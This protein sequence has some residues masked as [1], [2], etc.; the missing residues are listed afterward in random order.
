MSD[1]NLLKVF[2][3]VIHTKSVTKAAKELGVSSPAVSQA[4]NRLKQKYNDPL[5]IREGRGL[6]P[7]SFS[8][9]LYDKIKEPLSI[10]NNI[11]DFEKDF[12]PLTSTLTFRIQTNSDLDILFYAN[13]LK[14]L[15]KEAPNLNIDFFSKKSGEEESIQESL[16]Y[17]KTDLTIS[18]IETKEKSYKSHL[19]SKE[20]IVGIA[21]ENNDIFK[22][23]I[24]L[25][26]F[27]NQK[28]AIYYQKRESD[29]FANSIA[30]NNLKERKS[31]YT[32]QS[33]LNLMIMCKKTNLIGI[34]CESYYNELKEIGGLKIFELP[35]DHDFLPI[36]VTS[37]KNNNKDKGIQWL[38]EILKRS[39]N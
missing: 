30:R 16:I 2:E 7:T 1:L 18:T 11:E 27:I 8:Y 25:D 28:H 15:E 32:T 20:K 19:L 23:D 5:F 10:L 22:K 4:L 37:H 39:F 31:S 17:R 6:K 12:N 29:F 3:T 14:I 35:F 33:V 21:N 36:Y 9:R 38:I 26:S 34:T 13:F 24:T